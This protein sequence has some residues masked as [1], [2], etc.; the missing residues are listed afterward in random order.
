[1]KR[2]HLFGL[3][4]ALAFAVQAA[5]VAAQS[6]DW[7]GFYAGVLGGWGNGSITTSDI[8]FEGALSGIPAFDTPLSGGMFGAT[9]GYNNQVGQFVL[10]V[11]GDVAYSLMHGEDDTYAP[12]FTSEADILAFATL[13][14]RAGFAADKF[15]IFASGGLAAASV[16]ATIHDVYP[17]PTTI[18]TTDTAAMFGWTAGLGGEVAVTDNVSI[19][20]EYLYYDLG[21]AAMSVN[22][23]APGYDLIEFNVA[24]I[25]SLARIGVN[26]HF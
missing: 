8:E 5:P 10:G 14:A 13:R 18:T 26:V 3:G 2:L 1:M 9:A 24:T 22:E 23:G 15:L 17:G 7:T 20:A 21:S 4:I 6:Y 11:E 25:G 16:K 19:K 12:S